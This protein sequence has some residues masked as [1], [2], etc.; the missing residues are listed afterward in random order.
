MTPSPRPT[1]G[2]TLG[3][4]FGA[5]IVVQPSTLLMLVLL[6]LLF[7]TSGGVE[8][9]RRTFTIGLILAI[10]LFVSV[11]LH[12]LAHAATARAFK[13][14]VSEI[15]L[16]LWGGH[17]SYDARGLTPVVAG[18]TSAA[19]P[20]A[21]LVLAGLAWLPLATGLISPSLVDWLRG[22]ITV[23]G[24]VA[25]L[26]WANVVLA[27]F[28]ALPGIP[29]DGGRVLEA[30]VWGATGNRFTGMKVAAWGGRVV[31]VGVLVVGL[32]IPYLQGRTPDLFDIGWSLL[33]V[34]ILWPAAS[35]ALRVAQALDKRSTVTAGALAVPAV[36]LAFHVSVADARAAAARDGAVEVVVLGVDGAAAGHF[37]VALTDAVEEADRPTTGLQSVTMPLPRGAAIDVEADG[38]ALVEALQEW[39]GKTDVWV[40]V[41]RGA[42]VGVVRLAEAMKALQ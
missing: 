40:A 31:A 26:A 5:R 38:D 29:M 16:T 23:Y 11:F 36:A 18:V 13:R 32:A 33:V 19:G 34:A 10:L 3:R 42:I 15:V 39:W 27:A 17:T 1:R 24:I 25:W 22:D 30:I 2:L 12:E 21:N 37:P 35:Q 20:V 6:A 8:L 28:N 41:D 4:V 7:A 14:D 9:D